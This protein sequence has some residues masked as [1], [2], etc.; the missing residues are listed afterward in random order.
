[1]DRTIEFAFG[2]WIGGGRTKNQKTIS[3]GIIKD[4]ESVMIAEFKPR[5]NGVGVKGYTG[6]AIGINSYCEENPNWDC[7]NWELFYE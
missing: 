4:I 3:E 7:L 1:M 2:Y 5:L 6:K